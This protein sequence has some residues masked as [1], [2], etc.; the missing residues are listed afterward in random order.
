MD[1]LRYDSVH[2]MPTKTRAAITAAVRARFPDR[3]QVRRTPEWLT[4]LAEW[5]RTNVTGGGSSSVTATNLCH[6]GPHMRFG[7]PMNQI[8]YDDFES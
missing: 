5:P 3:I 7:S 4:T 8:G 1:G 2:N 6:S